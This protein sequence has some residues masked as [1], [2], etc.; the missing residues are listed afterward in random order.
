MIGGGPLL[1]APGS[2]VYPYDVHP[3]KPKSD[4]IGRFTN[5]VKIIGCKNKNKCWFPK[6]KNSTNFCL[7]MLEF[8]ALRRAMFSLFTRELHLIALLNTTWCEKDKSVLNCVE[9]LCFNTNVGLPKQ[10]TL[11]ISTK[12]CES[13]SL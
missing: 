5:F 2:R 3:N 11:T 9:I 8:S 6:A 1:L 12:K 4:K 10:K 13:F 7:K